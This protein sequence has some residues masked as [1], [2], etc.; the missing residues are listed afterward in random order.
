MEP[1]GNGDPVEP[2]GTRRRPG[3]WLPKVAAATGAAGP[4]SRRAGR[5]R[6]LMFIR[7]RSKRR[8][9]SRGRVDHGCGDCRDF[10]NQ[11]LAS[12]L[13]AGFRTWRVGAL[14]GSAAI[15]AIARARP[16]AA[17]RKVHS[18][19]PAPAPSRRPAALGGERLG[20]PAAGLQGGL[21]GSFG[22]HRLWMSATSR[23]FAAPWSGAR[24][25]RPFKNT[26]SG[27]AVTP[28]LK[29]FSNADV[30]G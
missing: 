5:A 9:V 24:P 21:D 18:H 15:G 25:T 6:D 7:D 1:W 8:G 12:R 29:P 20:G 22:R 10:A 30:V 13:G 3:A 28:T 2:A 26:T 16:G 19:C 14:P 17:R 4:A 23:F 11:E 27:P